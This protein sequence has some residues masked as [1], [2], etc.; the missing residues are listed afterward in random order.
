MDTYVRDMDNTLAIATWEV[1]VGQ[2]D[3]LAERK[4]Q[5]ETAT[6]GLLQLNKA[7]KT[8]RTQKL[9]ELYL[10]DDAMYEAELTAKGLTFRKER[11]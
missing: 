8:L 6:E 1:S 2:R 4:R 9:K 5:Q 7:A 3:A 11:L 10:Q